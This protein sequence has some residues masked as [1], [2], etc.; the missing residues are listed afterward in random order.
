MDCNKEKNIC[1]K[2]NIGLEYDSLEDLCNKRKIEFFKDEALSEYTTFSIGGKCDYLVKPHSVGAL[3]DLLIYCRDNG[4]KYYILGRGSNV[5]VG[6]DGLRGV[7][8]VLSSA[9]SQI[10]E[11][12]EGIYCE[13]GTSLMKLC[14]YA[15]DNELTGLEFAYGIPGSVGG[16][17]Y[18][19][20]GAYGGEIKD[21]V[22]S[23][24]YLDE[25]LEAKT[26]LL[27]DMALS[28]RHSI[29]CERNYIILGVLFKL[30][31][32]NKTEI[33]AKMSELM[34]KRRSKQP[35]EYPSAGSTF[36][37]PEGD[38]AGRLIE[39]SGL[40][41]FTCGGAQVSEKHCGFVIN[42]GGATCKDVKDVISAVKE[43]VYKDSGVMLECEVLILE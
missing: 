39:A 31:K 4:I 9:F 32:G 15:K 17:L 36:K 10:T 33:A 35:L 29:F 37:R 27:E 8:I 26:M 34:E 12:E 14:S 6:D 13:A 28:Y 18:M 21:V 20:A 24:D 23:C 25:N 1:E 30:N 19:N 2:Y 22:A 11:S 5:L 7:V 41:G 38:F 40:K 43:K 16:A 3:R 42:K